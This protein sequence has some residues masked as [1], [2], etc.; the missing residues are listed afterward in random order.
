MAIKFSRRGGFKTLDL[1]YR[2]GLEDRLAQQLEN[3][4]IPKVYE[5]YTI[6]YTIPASTH[7]YTPDFIL[8][9]GIIVEA[10]GIFE[11]ADRKKHLLIREQYPNLDI[12]FVFSNAKTKIA[13]GAK[14]TVAE[15]CEKHGFKYASREIPNSWFKETM[16]D[17]TGL[18][19]RGGERIVTL[20]N[21]RKNGN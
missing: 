4:G 16:K 18:T 2:S 17:T 1:P 3:A 15:W 12:R 5:K 19:L 6:A 13:T 7:R 20:Q 9:N 21:P 11:P 8:P 10:K 14:T